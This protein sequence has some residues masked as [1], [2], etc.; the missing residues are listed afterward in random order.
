V[1]RF[2]GQVTQPVRLYHYPRPGALD[3][4]DPHPPG[5]AVTGPAAALLHNGLG[6]YREALDWARRASEDSRA[7]RFTGWALVELIEAAARGGQPDQGADALR[8]LCEATQASATDWALGTEA[9]SRALVSNGEAAERLYRE[10][11]DRL[12]RMPLRPDLARAHLLY[13][14][15]LRRERRR[16]DACEQLRHAYGMFTDCGM[17]AFAERARIELQATGERVRKRNPQTQADLT[18]QEA[19][20]ARLAA[21]GATNSEIAARL[22]ISANTVDY[23]LRKVFRKL[24]VNSRRQLTRQTLRA[25]RSQA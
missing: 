22:F 23:H 13:G 1:D 6:H 21:S 18:P 7:Q 3:P 11:I 2:Q 12:E 10:A 8:R 19:R 9:R 25:R 20:I 4:S 15:W 14:E 24:G 17:M 5:N 16:L